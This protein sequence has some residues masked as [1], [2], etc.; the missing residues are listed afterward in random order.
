MHTLDG[1]AAN[2][3]VNEVVVAVTSKITCCQYLYVDRFLLYCDTAF[4][5][6]VNAPF[7][8]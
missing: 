6:E 4:K 1:L 5:D 7:T 8:S 2:L 3:L